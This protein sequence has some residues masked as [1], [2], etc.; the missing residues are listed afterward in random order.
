MKFS[1]ILNWGWSAL[2][3]AYAYLGDPETG[4]SYGEKGI[5]MAKE[6]GIE[7]FLSLQ[8]LCMGD[9]H[10]QLGDLENARGYMEEAL[11]LS[12]KN[13]EKYW[14][15]QAWIFLGRT[16][17]RTAVPQLHKAEECILQ[18]MKIADELK[19]KPTYAQGHLFLGELYAHAGQKEEALEN[20]K[21][22]EAMLQQMGMVYWLARTKE[23]LETVRV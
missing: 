5:M 12:Q 6:A 9:T 14:E 21:K 3:H 15:A 11:R 22:A 2:G 23:L 8:N 4:R 20:L 10:L 7:W 18:G 13:N 17:G 1:L 16:L 19:A